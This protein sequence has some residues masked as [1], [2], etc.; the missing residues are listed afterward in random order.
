LALG[1]GSFTARIGGDGFNHMNPTGMQIV[2]SDEA[3]QPL[4]VLDVLY[5]D[6]TEEIILT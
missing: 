2:E 6:E 4:G 1:G 5:F 3:R